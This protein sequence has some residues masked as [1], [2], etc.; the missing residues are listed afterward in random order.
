MF[1]SLVLGCRGRQIGTAGLDFA[2]GVLAAVGCLAFTGTR[3]IK[4]VVLRTLQVGVR[5]CIQNA[6]LG[7]DKQQFWGTGSP[8][9][10]R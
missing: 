10:R 3:R 7:T 4:L 5:V 2:S 8:E 6:V 9:V 1:S